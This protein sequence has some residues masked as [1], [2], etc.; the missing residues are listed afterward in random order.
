M[1][2]N[3][4]INE[5]KCQLEIIGEMSIYEAAELKEQLLN[6]LEDCQDLEINLAQVSEIDTVGFQLLVLAKREAEQAEKTL[7]LVAHSEAAL[8]VIET[9]RMADYFGDPLVIPADNHKN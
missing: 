5:G 6:A 7:Q 9:Y 8:E 3:Q 2:I 1:E 4:Q